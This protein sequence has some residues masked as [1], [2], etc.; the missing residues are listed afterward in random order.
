[1]LED[2]GEGERLDEALLRGADV[3]PALRRLGAFLGAVHLGTLDADLAE[4]F[5]NDGMRRLHGDHTFSLPYRDNDFPLSPPLRERA[6]SLWRDA[7]LVETIDEAYAR[8]LTPEGVLVHGDVQGANV[9]LAE[10]GPVL[11]DAEI[12]HVGD[13]AFDVGSLVAHV[14][15]PAVARGEPRA[16]EAPLRAL[17]SAYE[18]CA[19]GAAPGYAAVARYAGIEMLRRTIGAARV[20]CVA[21]DACALAVVEA[22]VAL[23]RSPPDAPQ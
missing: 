6:E 2:L 3:T 14:L 7:R 8:Y 22:G 19:G 1:M 4:R 17:W 16:A 15:L 23:V 21:E 5:Q 9:L 10:R 12:A 18:R 11:L 13:P 20:A